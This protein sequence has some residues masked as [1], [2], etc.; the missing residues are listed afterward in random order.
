MR[1]I[2]ASLLILAA[3]ADDEPEPVNTDELT[4]DTCTTS[5]ADD[6]PDFYKRFFACVTI[7]NGADGVTIESAGLPPHP[8]SYYPADDP[9]WEEF[10]TSRG[11]EYHENPNT[12][13]AKTIAITIPDEPV[14]KGLPAIGVGIVDGEAG[15]SP[16][17]YA[18]GT[19]GVAL[20]SVA[21]YSGVA[22]PGDDLDDEVF[23]FDDYNAHPSPDGTYH[24]HTIMPGPMEVIAWLGEDTAIEVYGVLCDG[25]VVLGC[26]ELDG[27]EVTA[28][29]DAQGGHVGDL[30]DVDGMTHFTDRY[31]THVCADGHAY[32]PEIQYYTACDMP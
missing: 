21:L 13:S 15:N 3:C 5:I 19:I 9:N 6:V 14:A 24:Y 30:V 17:E 2:V 32:T 12:L 31:H 7:T 26:T 20:D 25:T 10:D 23:T 8:S 18:L 27:S 29:L 4:L 16:Y 1:T 11:P 22:G 28:T